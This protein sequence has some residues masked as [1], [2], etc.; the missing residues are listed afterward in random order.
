[1]AR[2]DN[3][4]GIEGF[5]LQDLLFQANVTELASCLDLLRPPGLRHVEMSIDPT[6][7]KSPVSDSG[8]IEHCRAK[9]S[10]TISVDG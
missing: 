10:S 4:R 1:M 5:R 3:F 6:T 7:K 2:R 8:Q 9:S